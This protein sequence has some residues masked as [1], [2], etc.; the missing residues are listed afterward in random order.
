MKSIGDQSINLAIIAKKP[1]AV[2]EAETGNL[3]QRT[4]ELS[5][6]ML[7]E[8]IQ[9]QSGLGFPSSAKSDRVFQSERLTVRFR[10][11]LPRI[12]E[13]KEELAKFHVKNETLDRIIWLN[14]L[15]LQSV[16]G[17]VNYTSA[18]ILG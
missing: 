10:S 17:V 14:S 5:Q 2:V 7:S 4:L 13:I 16:G 8:L 18:G 9:V 11:F 6:K 3:R 12:V 1:S 15:P